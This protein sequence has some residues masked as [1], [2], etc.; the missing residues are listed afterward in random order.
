MH[1]F[2]R[3]AAA[4]LAAGSLLSA[5]GLRAAE[6]A[7]Q[8]LTIGQTRLLT[9]RNGDTLAGR[10]WTVADRIN[11]VHDVY[12]K[13]LGL[14]VGKI[15]WKKYGNRTHLYLNGDYILAV[16]PADA[17]VNGYKTTEQLAV[18]WAKLLKKGFADTHAIPLPGRQP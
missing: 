13:Y 7:G 2:A 3:F 17:K 9:I 4:A 11:H 18:V 1:R 14:G 5:G 10:S 15:T 16:T 8:S 12:A 6:P